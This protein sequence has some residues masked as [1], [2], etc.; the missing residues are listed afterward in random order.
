MDKKSEHSDPFYK[1]PASI[2]KTSAEI[3]SEARNALRSLKT[4]RPFTPREE[5]R[6]LFGVA[7][8]RTS[9]NR[10]PSSFSLHGCSF[11]SS[12]SRPVSVTR[13]SPLD[14]RPKLPV[15][16]ANEE[17]SALSLPKPPLDPVEVRRIS[18]SR[19]RLF[20]TA[21]K[22]NFLPDK[23]TQ[24]DAV[25]KRLCLEGPL[26]KTGFSG[27]NEDGGS[28]ELNVNCHCKS[29]VQLEEHET[30]QVE[31]MS[32]KGT[33]RSAPPQHVSEHDLTG[34]D[35]R[36]S[37]CPS[38]PDCTDVSSKPGL[39]FGHLPES[40]TEAEANYW[41]EKITPLLNELDPDHTEVSIE[42]LCHACTRLHQALEEG[43][44][45]GR[46]CKRRALILKTLYR[47]VDIGSDQ[48]SL[49]LA[50][51]ILALKVSGK[52][53]L[54]VC[55]LL[56]KISRSDDNDLLFQKYSMFDSL[57]EVLQSEDL[58]ANGEAF[59]YCLGA[60]KFLSGNTELL[61]D[62]LAKGAVETLLTATLRN[63]ADLP[64]SRSKFLH[65]SAFSELCV[66][67]D[68]QISDKDVCTNIARIFSK[69]S[70]YNVCCVALA[71]CSRCYVSF[72]AA[73]NK[74]QKKQDLV[75]RLLFILGNLTAK[76]SQAREQLFTAEGS[77][78]SLLSL[79]HTYYE[80]DIGEK[81]MKGDGKA[82]NKNE[83]LPSAVEDILIKLIRVLANI[84]IHPSIG[85]ELAASENCVALLIRVLNY[86]SVDECEELV[87]NT[88]ATINNLS[89]YQGQNSIIKAR[90]LVVAELLLKLLI[91]DSMDGI[92]EAA[93]VFG[94][95]SRYQEVRDFIVQKKV[96]K[97]MIALLDAKHQD[98]CF[99]ACGVL[100]NLTADSDK[101]ALLKEEG[102]VQK[103]MDCLRDFGPS[104]WQLASLVCKTFWNFSENIT[105]AAL[106]F[107]V[108]ETNTLL[109]LLSSYLDEELAL[110]YS[111]GD[112]R[113]YHRACW[114]AE[115]RPVALQLLGRIQSHHTYLESLPIAS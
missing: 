73:L 58:I 97:F 28:A 62:I 3:V 70:S 109:A 34:R 5:Q 38:D 67:L 53:L 93:R 84:S 24:P 106:C 88:A 111:S 89:Y 75:V 15:P 4:Q 35:G 18:S 82:K 71:D 40:E 33:A 74:H 46:R 32:G 36:P 39:E 114:E 20:K 104:D 54:N 7:C 92:L 8:S 91:S 76:N 17:E 112:L 72:L 65:S 11:E 115:F 48:L 43:N 41:K 14:H 19:A 64:Q 69:L 52:N 98:V 59:L 108:E 110:D 27:R 2:H 81:Q 23:L 47:L 50:K 55:K 16:P 31:Q 83:K 80:L 1:P 101:R 57:L 51:V 30:K 45:L 10:P 100:I 79:F 85:A 6:Q 90:K 78:D 99:S 66:A 86:K 13:L 9:E 60:I 95:L 94:N 96:Y 77:M 29:S 87:I 113:E 68:Q 107:G 25:K 105:N 63:L 21:T 12:D 44:M 37:L 22:G 102:G 49:K 103:L 42:S 61:K 26:L 56:F